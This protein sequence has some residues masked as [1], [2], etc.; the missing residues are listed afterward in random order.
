MDRDWILIIALG[1]G[2]GCTFFFNEM[3]LRD[4][5]PLSV[6]FARVS[7]AAIACWVFLI[8]TGR[9]GT[10]PLASL[11]PLAVMGALMFATPFA[12]FP[13]GQQYVAT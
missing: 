6:S 1:I 2:W 3:L 10:V 8:V 12:V 13:I 9:N 7:T 11:A 5:G 4:M